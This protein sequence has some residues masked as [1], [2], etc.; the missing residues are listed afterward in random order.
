MLKIGCG[1]KAYTVALKYALT[2]FLIMSIIGELAESAIF[3][4]NM[5][6]LRKI[7]FDCSTTQKGN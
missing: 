7:I 5:A 6:K 2:N 3:K 4:G 1:N